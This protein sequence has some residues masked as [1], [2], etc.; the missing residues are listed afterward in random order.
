M[1]PLLIATAAAASVGTVPT[2]AAGGASE[3]YVSIVA[4]D[5]DRAPTRPV[6]R[7][8]SGE[9]ATFM[10]ANA[11]YS[12]RIVATPAADGQVALTGDYDVWTPQGL[13]H[14]ED[15]LSVRSDGQ[16]ASFAFACTDPANGQV[17]RMRFE[18]SVRPLAD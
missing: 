17:S 10:V 14:G 7:V 12:L 6:L 8:R 15:R 18:V 1:L 2:A 4:R 13:R 16:P 5:G 11:S 9:P 3:Y